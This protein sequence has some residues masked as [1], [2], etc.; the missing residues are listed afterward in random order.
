MSPH[1][2]VEKGKASTQG[3]RTTCFSPRVKEPGGD[4]YSLSLALCCEMGVPLASASPDMKS[5]WDCMSHKPSM[6]ESSSP[7]S[8]WFE[9]SVWTEIQ[10]LDPG[11]EMVAPSS[12]PGSLPVVRLLL[13]LL[14]LLCVCMFEVGD[15]VPQ[16]ALGSQRTTSSSWF[17]AC[18][19]GSE[20][21]SRSS[22]TT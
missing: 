18:G 16:C 8:S 20:V 13:L 4:W 22:L 7:S 6:E 15:D 19:E 1:P 11:R 17:S 14:L 12:H 9:G 10:N 3:N 2:S 5:R 21:S